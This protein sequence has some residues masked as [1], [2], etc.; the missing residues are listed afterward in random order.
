[1]RTRIPLNLSVPTN[2]DKADIKAKADNR[3]KDVSEM[4]LTYF[5]KLPLHPKKK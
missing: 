5:K 3:G 1:M 4:V 2:E